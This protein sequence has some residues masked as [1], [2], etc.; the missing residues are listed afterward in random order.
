MTPERPALPDPLDAVAAPGPW[1]HRNVAA[2]GARFHVAELGEGPLV[3]LLHGFPTYWWT[4]RSQLVAL[5]EAGYRAVA[6]DLRGYGGSDHTPHGYDPL[7]LAADVAGVV[8]SLGAPDAVLVGQGWGGLLAWTAAVTHPHVVRGIVP[9]SMP[10]PKRL[11]DALLAEGPQ[12]RAAGYIF[13]FQ[14]P[15]LPERS[16]TRDDAARVGGL[17]R[18]WSAAPEWPTAEA[19]AMF[20]AAMLTPATAHSPLEYHRWAIRS[21]PR[22]DG[23]RF[24]ASVAEAVV[25]PVLHVQGAQD[26]SMLLSSAI[27]SDAHVLGPYALRVLD[28]CGHFPQEERPEGLNALLLSWLADGMSW[29]DPDRDRPAP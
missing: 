11:R 13:G 20:R 28:D 8:R 1:T 6:M 26:P 3:L 15:F 16:L 25:A 4:W 19:E 14:L 21:I 12:R 27:G 2:N 7:T 24:V 23:R 10:H 18:E 9:L 29:D 5:A 22:R 17:L